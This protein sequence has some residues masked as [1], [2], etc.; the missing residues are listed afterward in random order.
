MKL[1]INQTILYI[2][3][4]LRVLRHFKNNF[5]DCTNLTGKIFEYIMQ[6]VKS[7]SNLCYASLYNRFC[8]CWTKYPVFFS[9]LR[10]MI[11]RFSNVYNTTST[12]EIRGA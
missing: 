7:L 9:H 12:G 3:R 8:V 11:S 6:V 1:C 2:E 10:S 5:G 4:H